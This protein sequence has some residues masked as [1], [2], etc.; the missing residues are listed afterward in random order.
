MHLL[1]TGGAGF[2]G[3]NFV[4]YLLEKEDSVEITNLDALTYA[5][6][7][8]NLDSV[9]DNERYTFIKGDVTSFDDVEKAMAGCDGVI[10]FAAESHVDK[11]ITGP[12]VFVNT[13]VLGTQVLLETARK[14]NVKK[15]LQVS[16]DEVYGSLKKDNVCFTEQT[17][18]APNSP[19]S[20][21]KAG[22]DMVVRSYFKTFGFP[23][24]ITR[25]SN[26]YGPLQFPEKLIPLAVTNLMEGGKIP[27]YAKGENVRDWLHVID[28]CE[29]LW[30]VLQ[31]GKPG[32]VYN[33]GGNNE[34]QNIDIVREILR[35]MDKDES[36]IEFVEDRPG[37]DL[38]YAIDATKIKEELGWQ[39]AYTFENGLKETV[40]W[41]LK[42]EAWWQPIKERNKTWKRL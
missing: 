6:N 19:Y 40:E 12:T 32:E 33:I 38:R 39:P 20:A 16:T 15:F 34:W 28:H 29:A 21:S 5:G 35:L 26:N 11:S 31:T 30:T 27:V 4:L 41:Y 13:N 42:N 17:P 10:N 22:A 14:M 9:K 18:L 23:A 7:I 25:C 8:A 37:H 2:I 24:L 1:V 3:S 36:H